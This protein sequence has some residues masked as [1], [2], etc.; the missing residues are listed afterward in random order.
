MIVVLSTEGRVTSMNLRARELLGFYDEEPVGRD[1]FDTFVPPTERESRR[2]IFSELIRKV[3]QELTKSEVRVL[4][5]GGRE[6]TVNWSSIALKDARNRVIAVLGLGEDAAERGRAEKLIEYQASL[7][8]N[9]TDAIIARDTDMVIKIWNKAAEKMYGW[10]AEE[11]IGKGPRDLSVGYHGIDRPDLRDRLMREGRVRW[12][13]VQERKDGGKVFVEG[14]TVTLR[15]VRGEAKGFLSVNRDTTERKIA[16]E[17][18]RD[19]R[20]Y[21]ESLVN[22]ANA[23][24][25]VWDPTF[26]ITRFNRA[27]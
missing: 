17:D 19:T 1:W 3:P 5:A 10:T 25:I 4:G 2:M 14:V 15:G 13:A 24:I 6:L 23:P 9:V 26:K 18:L 8:D 12:E 20:N 27:F 22:Y 16:E 7:I 21:L 11:V